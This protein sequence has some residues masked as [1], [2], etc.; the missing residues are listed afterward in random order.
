LPFSV[1]S[2]VPR[3]KGPNPARSFAPPVVHNA[4]RPYRDVVLSTAGLLAYY[5]LGESAGTTATE[6]KS[7]FD[8]TYNGSP[9]GM[10]ITGSVGNDPDT[11]VNFDGI[12]DYVSVPATVALALNDP[13]TIEFATYVASTDTGRVAF[14]I[15]L[16]DNPDRCTANVPWSDNVLYWDYGDLA[17]TGRIS[18]SMAMYLD[19]WVHIVLVSAGNANT[20]KAIYL[21]G[22]VA[23][24]AAA[25]DGPNQAISGGAIG[26]WASAFHKGRLDEFAIYNQVLS[27]DT[28][29]DHYD[30]WLLGNTPARVGNSY[31]KT[32]AVAAAVFMSGFRNV[33]LGK[34]GSLYTGAQDLLPSTVLVPTATLT[35]GPQLHGMNLSGADVF[36]SSETGSLKATTLLAG[37]SLKAAGN[38][39]G[40]ITAG[41]LI[42]GADVYTSS[43]TG[44]V[45][46]GGLLSGADAHTASRTGSVITGTLLSGADIY[47]SSETGSL[48]AAGFVAGA[49]VYTSSET[50]SLVTTGLASAADASTM[51][52]AGSTLA[53]ATVSGADV[54]TATETGS[55]TTGTSL[56]GVDIY[57]SSETGSLTLNGFLAGADVFTST[58]TGSVTTQGL[59]SGAD[60]HTADRTGSVTAG[61]LVSGADAHTAVRAGSVT[62]GSSLT[63]ADV[64]TSV[65]TGSLLTQVILSGTYTKIASSNFVKAGSILAGTILSAAD[66]YE[67]TETGLLSVRMILGGADMFA[68]TETGVLT[69]AVL[70]SAADQVTFTETATVAAGTLVQGGRTHT[71]DRTGSLLTFTRLYGT[72][73]WV[74]VQATSAGEFDQ[75]T[76]DGRHGP[77]SL[78]AAGFDV[79]SYRI[80]DPS[81]PNSSSFDSPKVRKTS[82]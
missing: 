62:A 29:R 82:V 41:G 37:T 31:D 51:N 68:S 8:G 18:A 79:V 16:L 2:H 24:S 17:G 22:Q 67:A 43:E 78:T 7:G 60:A 3:T 75:P 10:G 26:G 74:P 1:A 32:G 66:A 45:I 38:K 36:T 58:E 80:T 59:T 65:E 11:A 52:R 81:S 72:S 63:G 47:T 27:A 49:D 25:S 23:N 5:R 46:A 21:N 54:Y 70:P 20:F 15:G 53:G 44:S 6:L 13:V 34:T 12:D 4:Y 42:S 28:V 19:T 76:I 48:T 73:V 77:A 33:N 56:S 57:T 55:V 50:G 39:T 35:P 69:T 9:A 30:A 64:Y 71:A 61:G 14:S 40:S